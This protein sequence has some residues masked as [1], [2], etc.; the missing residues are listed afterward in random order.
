M[1]DGWDS[2]GKSTA[3]RVCEKVKG[4][5]VGKA[6]TELNTIQRSRTAH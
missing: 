1:M 3:Q 4:S 6:G 5:P 2:P